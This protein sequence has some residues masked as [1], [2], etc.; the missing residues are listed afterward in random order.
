VDSERGQASVE[1]VALLLLVA[2]G[3]GA[4]VAI[5]PRVEGRSLGGLLAQRIACAAARDC[6][7]DGEAGSSGG[8]GRR[9]RSDRRE[10]ASIAPVAPVITRIRGRP[11]D[12]IRVGVKKAIAWNGLACYLRKSTA[13]NDTN[14]PSDDIGD[15]VNCLNPLS[16]WTGKVG[17]T[18]G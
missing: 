8:P 18:D 3:L 13:R 16:G 4:L 12:V 7:A 14:R 15:A 9:S 6:G 17:R 2:L 11:R 5:A 10:A 1:W